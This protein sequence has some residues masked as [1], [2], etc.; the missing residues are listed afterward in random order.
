M[1]VPNV[2][3]TPASGEIRFKANGSSQTVS[4]LGDNLDEVRFYGDTV[5]ATLVSVFDSA[6]DT[7]VPG[8]NDY[9]LGSATN[10]WRLRAT[11][12]NL[13]PGS[14]APAIEFSS[15]GTIG[16]PA[17]GN[18]WYDGTNLYFRNSTTT[19]NLTVI[20]TSLTQGSVIFAGSGGTLAEDNA[21]FFFDNTNNTLGIG[22]TRSGAISGT[23]PSVRILGTGSSSATSSFEVQ[24]SGASTI[25][26]VRNDGRVA[27]GTN[28]PSY[29]ISIGGQA[30]RQ[31]GM[32]RRT[33]GAG[34]DLT[35]SAGGAQSGATD[36]NAGNLILSSGT[37]TGNADGFVDIYAVNDAGIISGSGDNTPTLH[38]RVGGGKVGIG[39]SSPLTY[40]LTL[41]NQI[42]VAPY[43][44]TVGVVESGVSAGHGLRI[45][46]GSV[47][48][49]SNGAGGTLT[50]QSGDSTGTGTSSIVFA[51]ATAGLPGTLQ[52]AVTTKMTLTGA[53]QL[54]VSTAGAAAGIL[55][56]GDTQLYRSAAD[57]ITTPD[58]LVVGGTLTVSSLTSTR[59]PFASTAGLLVDSSAFTYVTG[60]GQLSLSTTGSGAGILIGGDTQL[61]RSAADV[62]RTPDSV[63]VDVCV[64]VNSAPTAN[65]RLIAG[66]TTSTNV[67]ARTLSV[68]NDITG[69]I[70]SAF[71]SAAY[72][73]STINAGSNTVSYIAGIIGS[74]RSGSGQSGTITEQYGIDFDNWHSGAA[75]IGSMIAARA[76][77]T[78]RNTS[79]GTITEMV[80]YRATLDMQS[81]GT[82]SAVT[83]AFGFDFAGSLAGASTISTLTGFRMTNPSGSQTINTLIGLRIADLTRGGTNY[84]IYLD[85]TSGL[86][87]QGIWW[88]GDTNLYRS[89]AD[90][91]KTDDAFVATTSITAGNLTSTRVVFAGTAG[92][93]SDS[94]NF[95]YTTGTGQLALATTGSGGGILIGGDT[96]LYR[97]SADV[98]RT[99]DSLQVDTL[100]A[101]GATPAA[102]IHGSG[103]LTAA[104]WTTNGIGLR[105]DAATYTDSSSSGTVASQAGYGLGRPTFAASSTTTYTDAAALYIS[106]SPAA[107]TNVTITNP[108][109]L[110]VDAGASR[111]DGSVHI[112]DT[113]SG[114]NGLFIHDSDSTHSIKIQAPATGSLTS[115]YTITLPANDGDSGQVLQTDGS[116]A[117]SWVKK[118]TRVVLVT[119][120]SG[121]TPSGT[122]ADSVVFRV[123]ESSADG[124]TS[125]TYNVRRLQI[126]VETASANT[127]SVQVERSTAAGAFS[128]SNMMSSA[129]SISGSSTYEAN[130]QTFSTTTVASGDKMRLN[131]T[132]LGA[133]HATFTITLLLE[134]A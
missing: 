106:N 46:A 57:V 30:A 128:G 52:N 11:R 38:M 54:Q 98:L 131:F 34:L 12:A 24:N 85:G 47:S 72:G 55:I 17:D 27:V 133:G 78:V 44:Y 10:R 96:Q 71:P 40:N 110:W 51:T 18:L 59:V 94:A 15:S 56:G 109:A 2:L 22:T 80:G 39:L 115:S 127:T 113:G 103:N 3:I 7:L 35:V 90:T 5:A 76:F 69:S 53:G 114:S 104:A 6:N 49:V 95:T 77:L 73:Q 126:R 67:S 75:N 62:L 31:I 68:T 8:A 88:N 112:R 13:S 1:S 26:F 89:A 41:A 63:R 16:S 123:P 37:A 99:P 65:N 102:R 48:A 119:F 93:L 122:G 74:V 134:E 91:L 111:F 20:P 60:T 120:C 4:I 36:A 84:A 107:G 132:A 81:G 14:G 100:F 105:L 101:A 66:H 19:Y 108:W 25:L 116:G 121:F 43:T 58:S 118:D 33:S 92:L 28:A 97:T 125:V 70:T 42:D 21:N 129:L 79:S 87:R 61:Y 83:N 64:G 9:G 29:D 117:T 32:E 124:T 45:R 82:N 86:A 23:N 130:T 50:L